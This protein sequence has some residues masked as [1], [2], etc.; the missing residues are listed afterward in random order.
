MNSFDLSG[1]VAIVIGENR[2]IGLAIFVDG[3][4]NLI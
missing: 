2:G 4:S 3:G 1:K